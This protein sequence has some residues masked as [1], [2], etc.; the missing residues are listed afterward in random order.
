MTDQS[1][2]PDPFE[3]ALATSLAIYAAD[4][5]STGDAYS[6]AD[7]MLEARRKR[8]FR[9][10]LAAISGL[11]ATAV[12]A[13]IAIGALSEP[14]P[15]VGPGPT[16]SVSPTESVA[17]SS[18]PTSTTLPGVEAPEAC[19]FPDGTPLSYAGRSTTAT[20]DVQQVVGDS[21]SFEPAD[22][23]ITAE[24]Q[25]LANGIRGRQVCAIFVNADFVEVTMHPA[26]G[27]RF[28]PTPEPSALEASCSPSPSPV[29]RVGDGPLRATATE[30]WNAGQCGDALARYGR[31]DLTLVAYPAGFG[32]ADP[33]PPLEP[34]W[35][36]TCDKA[37]FLRSPDAPQDEFGRGPDGSGRN[38]SRPG[39]DGGHPG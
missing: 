6:I 8:R 5:G 32:I 1:Q 30:L 29:A 4:A 10:G 7:A 3:E 16:Q 2:N 19:G 9:V 14:Q 11:L 26:D 28:S 21:W 35:F 23:Y 36:T 13:G 17:P 18:E 22:I 25:E 24:K 39:Q 33:C 15:Q 20:L 37:L 27:G 31:T 38:P 12:L 34:R